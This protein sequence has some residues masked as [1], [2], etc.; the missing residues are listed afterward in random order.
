M[1]YLS[2]EELKK[3]EFKYLGKNVLISDKCS[4]Y[5][6]EKIEIC[7]NS[8]IDDFCVLSGKIKIGR[9][10]HLAPFCLIAGG[11]EGVELDDFSGCAYHVQVFSQSDDYT[12]CSM[13]NPTIPE[14]YK[15]VLRKKVTIGK[16]VIIGA[17]S[18]VLPGVEIS[19]GCSVGAMS[20][21]TK[22]TEPWGV[23]FGIPAKRLK[24][25]KK[26]LLEL[27]KLYLVENRK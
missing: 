21:I 14:K 2:A 25:R 23:Y 26:N 6:P 7:D 19:E 22:N 1:S 27:E 24:N 15:N 12:G 5:N 13:T 10:V 11:S 3:I 18:I 16:H 8:R 4:I 17:S 9:N 20:L